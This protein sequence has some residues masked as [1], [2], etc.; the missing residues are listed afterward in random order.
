MKTSS[1]APSPFG[2]VCL[3]LLVTFFATSALASCSNS[4]LFPGFQILATV[5]STPATNPFE[6]EDDA[7]CA[8]ACTPANTGGAAIAW[9]RDSTNA[10]CY[11]LKQPF[12][13]TG[14]SAYAHS[15][16]DSGYYATT[17]SCNSF[18]IQSQE[19][20]SNVI[21]S[22]YT[23]TFSLCQIWCAAYGS[24]HY[25]TWQYTGNGNEDNC[26]CLGTSWDYEAQVYDSSGTW[27]SGYY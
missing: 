16:W 23:S 27:W 4:F 13:D 25:S 24:T 7:H 3:S 12:S 19:V 18:A 9:T 10:D 5:T 11:C 1:F 26:Y 17:A 15:N 14:V 20:Q 8:S 22:K 2:A 21:S 6:S